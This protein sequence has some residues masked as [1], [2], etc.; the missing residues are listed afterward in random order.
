MEKNKKSTIILVVII[1]FLMLAI[2]F[3]GGMLLTKNN[4]IINNYEQNQEKNES[5]K[6]TEENKNE[7]DIENDDENNK[8]EQEV[9]NN[10]NNKDSEKIHKN[11]FG[12]K[13]MNIE[14]AAI[15]KIDIGYGNSGAL[16]T[17]IDKNG[18]RATIKLEVTELDGYPDN[19]KIYLNDEIFYDESSLM[20]SVDKM[21]VVDLDA[22][23]MYYDLVLFGD[24]AS[25]DILI[26]FL[27]IMVQHLYP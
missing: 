10:D 6:V 15:A 18:K 9:E 25:A 4:T 12:A 23:D 21:Y 1:S 27:N 24:M 17:E 2:G 8:N 5:E 14:D 16:T 22:A 7:Q 3:C 11:I 13:L 26:L 20:R 19:Y